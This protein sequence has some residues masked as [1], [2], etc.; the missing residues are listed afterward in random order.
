MKKHYILMGSLFSVLIFCPQVFALES[1]GEIT[2][3]V[4]TLGAGV[5]FVKPINENVTI[6]LGINGYTYSESMDESG[7]SY[8]ADLELQTLSLI[9]N[10]HPW[11]GIFRVSGGVM[12]NG[13]NFSITA[14]PAADGTY[15]FN[16]ETYDATDVGS[17]TGEIDFNNMAPYIGIGL[18]KSPASTGW[19]LD[20]NV[21][22]LYQGTPDAS[23]T[24]TCGVL[25]QDAQCTQL[26][27]DLASEQTELQDELDGFEWYP[28]VS[29]G[30]SY[31]F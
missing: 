6:G 13:N 7:V 18:G 23:L 28:V 16:G 30:V 22:L 4:S 10:Y 3:R 2:G 29:L 14:E 15:E 26:Q 25:L 17:V 11:A 21:G 5:E 27:S 31:M 20:V 19:S 24:A 1:S 8:E 9:A 12:Y